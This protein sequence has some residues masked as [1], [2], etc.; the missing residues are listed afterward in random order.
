[1]SFTAKGQHE[2]LVAGRQNT[3][4]RID[5]EKGNIVD[6]VSGRHLLIVYLAYDLPSSLRKIIIP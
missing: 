3:M 6:T 1:M 2:I 4:F 5:V